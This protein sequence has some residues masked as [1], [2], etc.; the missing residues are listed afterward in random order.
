MVTLFAANAFNAGQGLQ[1]AACMD[2]IDRQ[3]E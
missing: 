2:T 3:H 1:R